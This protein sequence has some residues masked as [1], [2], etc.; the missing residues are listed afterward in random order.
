MTNCLAPALALVASTA[1]RTYPT[2]NR[3]MKFYANTHF[4][5]YRYTLLSLRIDGTILD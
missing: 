3:A 4:Y 2:N 5:E 1:C